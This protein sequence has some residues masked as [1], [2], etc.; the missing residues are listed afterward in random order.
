M[1]NEIQNQKTM[2]NE[3]QNEK[4]M[5]N[6]IQNNKKMK[7]QIQKSFIKHKNIKTIKST[8]LKNK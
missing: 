2:E 6:K 7:N 8:K 4:T 3:I 5:E 1:K